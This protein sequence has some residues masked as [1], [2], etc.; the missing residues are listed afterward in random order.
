MKVTTEMGFHGE[1][2]ARDTRRG[3]AVWAVL[4]TVVSIALAVV[5]ERSGV[6]HVYR[7]ALQ[8]WLAGQDLYGTGG[9]G[10][11][12][13]PISVIFYF[14]LLIKPVLLG[15]ILWRSFTIGTFALGTLRLS[16]LASGRFGRPVFGLLSVVGAIVALPGARDGQ[17]T[18]PMAGLLMLA[19]AEAAAGRDTRS[20]LAAVGSLLL[21]PL[22]IPVMLL[23]GVCRPRSIPVM[24]VG[25]AILI[26]MP[27]VIAD[28]GWV[29]EQYFGFRHVLTMTDNLASGKWATL[30]GMAANFGMPWS[31]PVRHAV[32]LV[33]AFGTLCGCLLAQKSLRP[34]EAATT[35][36]SLAMLWLM[37][38]SPRT[39]NN[40][41][42][43]IAPT[44]GLGLATGLYGIGPDRV[45]K[46]R[47]RVTLSIVAVALVIGSYE[48][49]KLVAPERVGNWLAPLAGTFVLL[50]VWRDLLFNR[51]RDT[52]RGSS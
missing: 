6:T 35:M 4:L 23:L 44:L 49:G 30:A 51:P 21:K 20:G 29:I 12:Y 10:F 38:F 43:C 46:S 16:Q 28:R 26:L 40:T 5:P 24:A 3:W 27:F 47:L 25:V 9:H 14:P 7:D 39:E 2:V 22:S 31:A 1:R 52:A 19:F 36:Y 32:S 18:F 41:Y 8:H 15:E 33:A 50:D 45:G 34:A 17:A 37:L 42:I 48:I 11:L 13:L